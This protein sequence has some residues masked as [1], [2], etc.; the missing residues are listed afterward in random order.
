MN[1]MTSITDLVRKP[2][3]TKK[4]LQFSKIFHTNYRMQS[5]SFFSPWIPVELFPWLPMVINIIPKPCGMKL[6]DVVE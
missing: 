5:I 1:L 4:Q 3:K 2:E 6:L